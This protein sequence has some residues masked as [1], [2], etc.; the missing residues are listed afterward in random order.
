MT[1]LLA[2]VQDAR[3]AEAALAG[4]ADIIDFKN[5]ADGALGALPP[6]TIASGMHCLSGRAV[7]SATAGDWP[8]DPQ[9]LLRAVQR[10]GATGVS[11]V[12]LGLLAGSGLEGCIEALA[13]VAAQYRLVAV[14][15]ADRGVPLDALRNLR[16]AGFA[17]AMIDTFDKDAGGLRRH[18]GEDTLRAFVFTARELGLM[19]GLA[20]SLRL[21]DIA[22]LT[23]LEPDLLGFRGALC[24]PAG[25]TTPLSAAKVRAVRAALDQARLGRGVRLANPV[26]P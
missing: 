12:K 1:R 10:I 17:G 5:T 14:F 8:L 25:R 23:T 26:I 15:F 18:L 4:G 21:E 24:E 20:G 13:S 16:G 2:S 9:L 19:T 11:Y 22:A 7:T 3:E 6:E